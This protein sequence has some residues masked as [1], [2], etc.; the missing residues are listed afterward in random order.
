[1]LIKSQFNQNKLSWKN[2][3]LE[4][5][6][7]DNQGEALPW[8]SYGAIE[9]LQKT[10]KAN[11]EI[12]EFGC[13]ASTI[14]FAKRVKQVVALET[15]WIW[16]N[17]IKEKLKKAKINNVELI[18]MKD[19]LTNINYENFAKNYNQKFDIIIVDSL[20]RF[21][22]AKNSIHALKPEGKIILDDSE[23]KNYQKIFDFFAA[24]NFI[25]EDFT[26]IA[27]G[28]LKIKSTSVFKA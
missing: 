4:G 13:G 6:S 14:F 23:R 19:G 15:S 2:S 18:L 5:F 22:C 12:F 25:R 8:M 1:M 28:Q 24:N 11:D 7:Q 16:F 9:F 27:P 20:K 17:I 21:L 26:G 3:F 10:L